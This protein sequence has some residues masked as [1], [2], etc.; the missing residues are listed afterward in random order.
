MLEEEIFK[1]QP[2][3]S[4]ADMWNGHLA[5]LLCWN[6]PQMKPF[7]RQ[8][9]HVSLSGNTATTCRF[10]DGLLEL[11]S[12]T[13]RWGRGGQGACG[14]GRSYTAGHRFSLL[15]HWSSVFSLRCCLLIAVLLVRGVEAALR[16]S[17]EISLSATWA[18]MII[19]W[20]PLSLVTQV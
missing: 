14:G 20:L 12:P 6:G 15:L 11:W 5:E 16:G 9:K 19:H 4:W 1:L 2:T 10:N 13:G 17:V 8:H 18:V 3:S 7:A